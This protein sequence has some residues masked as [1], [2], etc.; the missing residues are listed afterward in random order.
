[1]T[2]NRKE[3]AKT[4]VVLS[5]HSR[6]NNKEMA[7]FV[8]YFL[9]PW[10]RLRSIVL[11]KPVLRIARFGKIW[12]PY[13]PVG[14]GGTQRTM[15]Q[16]TVYQAAFQGH[17]IVLYG[18]VG[19]T[20]ISF[21]ANIFEKLG[22]DYHITSEGNKITVQNSY[23][24]YGCIEF[25]TTGKPPTEK[26]DNKTQKTYSR[27]L[28]QR[29]LADHQKEPYDLIHNHDKRS[30]LD[31]FYPA[32]LMLKTLTHVHGAELKDSFGQSRVPLL[33]ISHSQANRMQA[34]HNANVL[35][36]IYEG[37]DHF[38]YTGT[39]EHAGYLAWIGRIEEKK[40]LDIAIA[41]AHQ[42]GLP[43]VFAGDIRHLKDKSKRYFEEKVKKYINAYD[44][45][46]LNKTASLSVSDVR[47]VLAEQKSKLKN[48][49]PVILYAGIADDAQKQTL[50]G[51]ALATLFPISWP[52]PFGLVLIESMACGTPVI[53]HTRFKN[54]HCG[55]TEE[56]IEDGVTGFHLSATERNEAIQLACEKIKT[57]SLLDRKRIRQVFERDWGSDKL[58]R[59]IDASYWRLLGLSHAEKAELL[60]ANGRVA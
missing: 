45:T 21:A 39:T 35:G 37:L 28:A 51:N 49:G 56:I 9:R 5:R 44:E 22:L 1:M 54:Q 3:S 16:M 32:G 36:V 30:T 23:W 47:E 38:T 15:V 31:I 53:A 11:K 46:F 8:R 18:P 42:S 7:F 29:L 52:E 43:L 57:V 10:R 55:A 13:P 60:K 48:N 20:I 4:K 14:C 6:F 58:A 19:S 40:G 17:H 25:R 27:E 33:C 50:Y 59:K 24:R 12:K 41:I 34:D 26:L 2:Q